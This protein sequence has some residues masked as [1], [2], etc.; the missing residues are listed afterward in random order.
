VEKIQPAHD[1]QSR[2]QQTIYSPPDENGLMWARDPIEKLAD[3]SSLLELL[4]DAGIDEKQ[5]PT[6]RFNE[7]REKQQAQFFTREEA[8][9]AVEALVLPQEHKIPEPVFEDWW[10]DR[11]RGDKKKV[12]DRSLRA[13]LAKAH[14]PRELVT[15]QQ[16]KGVLINRGDPGPLTRKDGTIVRGISG[17]AHTMTPMAVVPHRNHKRET[18]GFKFA[19]ESFVRAE[20]WVTEKHGKQNEVVKDKDGNVLLEYHRRLIPHPRGLKNLRLRI[21][22]CT[23]RRLTWE[24]ALTDAEIIELGLKDNTVVRRLR[25]EYETNVKI[26]EKQKSKAKAA[27]SE[28]TLSKA[29]LAPAIP[30]P[31]TISLRRIYC[32]LPPHAKRLTNANGADISRLAKG[33][34]LLV[35]VNQSGMICGPG[36]ATYRE[37]WYRV[38]ALNTNGQIALKLAGFKEVK[39]PSEKE[40]KEGKSLT[41]GQEW[42]AD[43]F[44]QQPRDNEVIARLLQRTCANDQPSHS[45]Q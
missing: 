23:G 37:I 15:D 36:Q 25:K 2:F 9:S 45:G 8:L 17:S 3:K 13:L 44:L 32:G 35:P 31:A 39:R 38:T 22:Q 20:I 16:L 28:L 29:G 26:H 34:L 11:L 4:R 43:A 5:L 6:S 1:K 42:L 12:T 7:W 30:K 14:V 19:T 18:I 33:D 41:P 24:R 27:E 10:T 40:L 21:M